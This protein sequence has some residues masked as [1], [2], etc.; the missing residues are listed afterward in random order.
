MTLGFR[1]EPFEFWR[2]VGAKS[3]RY[4]G[5]CQ[6]NLFWYSR[7]SSEALTTIVHALED[8]ARAIMIPQDV[9]R[10]N[11]QDISVNVRFPSSGA[12]PLRS[13]DASKLLVPLYDYVHDTIPRLDS[14]P[15][16][17]KIE[18]ESNTFIDFAFLKKPYKMEIVEITPASSI[19]A[20]ERPDLPIPQYLVEQVLANT[21]AYLASP[22]FTPS[23]P[24]PDTQEYGTGYGPGHLTW[25]WSTNSGA[26]NR[27]TWGQSK[28]VLDS[29]TAYFRRTGWRYADI[30]VQTGATG[31]LTA[32]AEIMVFMD[33]ST[34]S[35]GPGNSSTLSSVPI[36]LNGSV[37]LAFNVSGSVGTDVQ[38]S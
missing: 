37:P 34:G 2:L 10:W 32:V 20:I 1:S 12:Y 26:P 31:A 19:F 25:D 21:A 27:L 33:I 14:H 35:I 4:S 7:K 6:T 5:T 8:G 29:V 9:V 28:D 23:T 17:G 30:I 38:T 13:G 3:F 22:G 24:V 16:T 15:C 18:Y 11:L 36:G